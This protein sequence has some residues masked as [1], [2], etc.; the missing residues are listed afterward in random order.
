MNERG[1]R[2]CPGQFA[3]MFYFV[4]LNGTKGPNTLGRDIF[5]FS[6]DQYGK[7]WS[8][9]FECITPRC[10]DFVVSNWANGDNG[11]GK[12]D[13]SLKEAGGIGLGCAARIIENGWKIDY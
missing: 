5:N 8:N 4:D 3:G 9:S 7:V 12:P 11:C 1:I 2:N 13:K 10:L 6:V